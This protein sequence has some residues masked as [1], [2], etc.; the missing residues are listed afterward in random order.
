MK[1]NQS[2][3]SVIEKHEQNAAWGRRFVA[4]LYE[5]LLLAAV[6]LIAVGIFQGLIQLFAGISPEAFSG[7]V[8]V[9]VLSGVW[10]L[11]VCF[12]Y[13]GWCWTRGQTLAMMTWRMRIAPRA[14]QLSWGMAAVRFAI[15]S[16]F[17][18][19]L[20]P[21]WVLAIYHPEAKLWAWLGTVWF[22][23]PWLFACFDADKQLLQDRIA[24]TRIANS[25]PK[26]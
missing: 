5:G 12:A 8:W 20:L 3:A 17:Y 18:L 9:R 10:L 25:K 26:K 24:K 15:A 22:F 1:S 23:V 4:F 14:G 6:L 21:L 19:P 13:F 11:A 16:V 2:A 7:L